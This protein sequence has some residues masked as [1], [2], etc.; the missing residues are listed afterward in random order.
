MGLF[1]YNPMRRID[2]LVWRYRKKAQQGEITW[3]QADSLQQKQYELYDI[4][5]N[6]DSVAAHPSL[7]S[8]RS[9]SV[10]SISELSNLE[11]PVHIA[12][13][14]LDDV[15][16]YCDL[17]PLYFLETNKTNYVLKRYPNLDHNFF[18]LDENF[19]PD[20]N[21]GKWIEVMNSFI[22]WTVE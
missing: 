8:W 22:E 14:S 12:F 13:G 18:P 20:Y 6:E 15:A 16:E 11:I 19:Q 2:Q 1:G 9:F 10:S 7:I 17:L 21:N 5:L 4:I 3:E